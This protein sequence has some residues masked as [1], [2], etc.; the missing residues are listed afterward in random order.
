MIDSSFQPAWW[1]RSRHLQTLWPALFRKRPE[2]PL[3]PE[4]VELADGDFIDLAWYARANSPTVMVIHGLEGNLHSHY[5]RPTMQALHAAGFASVFMHM[6]GCS[7]EPNRLEHSYHSGLSSD[8]AEVLAYLEQTGRLPDAAIGFSLGGNL[9]LKY[10]GETGAAARLKTAVAIS[11]PFQLQQCARKLEQGLSKI[12][13]NYLLGKLKAAYRAKFDQRSG[14]LN[15]DVDKLETIYAFDDQVT[16]PL[17]GFKDADEYYRLSSSA[18]FMKTIQVPTLVVHARDDPF[19]FPETVPAKNM[20]SK[21]VQ[22]ELTAH[23][24]HVGFI[25]GNIPGKPEFWL[26]RRLCEWLIDSRLRG[27][28]ELD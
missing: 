13:G 3:E 18:Q 5:A 19:M 28:D 6:R 1:L 16:A 25:S 7:G 4:R 23:G 22:L 12:Y 21:S 17:N 20:L 10:L 14:S 8:V 2:L 24:G 9:L 26:D 15:I 27:S 11:V